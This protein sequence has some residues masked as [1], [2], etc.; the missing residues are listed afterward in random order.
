MGPESLVMGFTNRIRPVGREILLIILWTLIQPLVVLGF[1]RLYSLSFL[2]FESIVLI[3]SIG[4]IASLIIAFALVLFFQRAYY[5][6]NPKPNLVEMYD[7]RHSTPLAS[8]LQDVVD[9]YWSLAV[10][11][12]SASTAL[13]KTIVNMIKQGKAFR[14]PIINSKP[15]AQGNGK[16]PEYFKESQGKTL[17]MYITSNV[18]TALK[19]F[20]DDIVANLAPT[21]MALFDVKE[22]NLPITHTMII[23]DPDR[24][25]AKIRFEPFTYVPRE[26]ATPVWVVEKAKHPE[27]FKN[28]LESFEMAYKQAKPID[29]NSL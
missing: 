10:T 24:P 22:Y 17:H 28:L 19:R 20:R 7:N 4:G 11:Q 27:V 26:G 5:S 29:W 13:S 2:S 8:L 9:K 16:E 21:E 25:N 18:E 15:N 6:R 23:I 3:W 12:T 1:D 14:F